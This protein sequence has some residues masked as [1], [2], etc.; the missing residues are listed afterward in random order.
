MNDNNQNKYLIH[1]TGFSSFENIIEEKSLWACD[2]IGVND[3][4]EFKHF[5]ETLWDN[6]KTKFE[7][8]AE[9]LY[10]K[11]KT[12]NVDDDIKYHLYRYIT[13]IPLILQK[14]IDSIYNYLIELYLPNSHL[15]CF[16]KSNDITQNRSL[17]DRYVKNGGVMIC[18]DR[19]IIINRIEENL[20][21]KKFINT[22]R[23]HNDDFSKHKFFGSGDIG[24]EMIVK[25]D[26]Y[27]YFFTNIKE[28]FSDYNFNLQHNLKQL[29]FNNLD[30]FA[31]MQKSIIYCYVDSSTKKLT[32]ISE[33]EG[34]LIE[35]IAFHKNKT[36]D[37]E[38]EYRFLFHGKGLDKDMGFKNGRSYISLPI[39]KSEEEKD[40][41]VIEKVII[42]SNYAN[43]KNY[44]IN[45]LT[46]KF[47][48]DNWSEKIEVS[49]EY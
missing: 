32:N 9:T 4:K 27:D 29:N 46:K 10:N 36:W 19:E 18:F 20:N 15:L 21:L 25:K 5:K 37:D 42:S 26:V 17:W 38:S 8:E 16:F 33:I 28:K 6:L 7:E 12:L 35:S 31:N 2:Y 34:N 45:Y 47:P 43:K 41:S 48:K 11:I 39:T 40:S 44:L 22:P 3:G 30:R 13:N 49:S 1:Y 14:E 24:Y 23:L